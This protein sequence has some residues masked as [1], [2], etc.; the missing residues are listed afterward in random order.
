[1]SGWTSDLSYDDVT[2]DP[3]INY[4]YR[5]QT[6]PFSNGSDAGSLSPADIGWRAGVPQA[7]QRTLYVDDDG[8]LDPGP[9]TPSRSD[10]LEDGSPQHSFDRI[11]EGIDAALDGEIVFVRA[12]TYWETITLASKNVILTGID[13]EDPN[14]PHPFPVIDANSM[15]TVVSFVD[16]QE[17]G[18]ALTGFVLTGGADDLAGAVYCNRSQPTISHCVI[19]GNQVVADTG[20]MSGSVLFIDSNAVITNCTIAN[21]LGNPV[22]ALDSHVSIANCIVWDNGPTDLVATGEGV[23]SVS[24]SNVQRTSLPGAASDTEGPGNTQLPPLFVQQGRWTERAD[25][26]REITISSLNWADGILAGRSGSRTR[27]RALALM[28]EIPVPLLLLSPSRMAPL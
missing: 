19:V 18:G 23:L 7:A 13:P 12:G 22:V 5:V 21:N 24:Y 11:Q 10:P 16:G 14:T 2:A 3:G 20:I 26:S 15:G 17:G 25:G 4:S 8:T 6:S 1:M 28:R 27:S 9:L